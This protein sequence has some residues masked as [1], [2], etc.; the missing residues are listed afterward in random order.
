M[1]Q[2]PVHP[3][4]PLKRFDYIQNCGARQTQCD[5][6]GGRI[7]SVPFGCV[8]CNFKLHLRCADAL[9]RGLMHDSHEHRL[10]YANTSGAIRLGERKCQIC[11]ENCERPFYYC[12]ECKLRFHW[13]CLKIPRSVVDKSFHIHPLVSKVFLDDSLEYC[14][15]CEMVVHAGNHAYC[16]ETCDFLSHIEC[17]LN[18]GAAPSPLYLKDLYSCNLD[19]TDQD[20]SKTIHFENKHVVKVVGHTHVLRSIP[21]SELGKRVDCG[22]CRGKIDDKACKCETCKFQTHDFCAELGK[23]RMRQFHSSH[24]L[25]LLPDFLVAEFSTVDCDICLKP[26]TGFNL[27]CRTCRFNIHVKCLSWLPRGLKLMVRNKQGCFIENHPTFGVT[28]SSSYLT[29]CTIC[30]ERLCGKIVS[31]RD[32]GDVYHPWCITDRKKREKLCRHPLHRDHDLRFL[33]VSGSNCIF[34][35][36]KITKY[37]Y[38][39]GECEVSFH[40]KCVEAVGI[41]KKTKSVKSH[42]HCLYNFWEKHST[43][44]CS[45]CARGCG[46]SFY[47]CIECNFSAHV[48]CI[49]FPDNVKNQR[50]Q[51]TVK[52]TMS[53]GIHKNSCSL[54]GSKCKTNMIY[55]CEHCKKK[56]HKKCIMSTVDREFA[57]EEDQLQDIYLM[58]IEKYFKKNNIW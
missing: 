49:G 15:V 13:K 28:V 27:F 42:F 41:S 50:H 5:A 25:T 10:I 36:L 37:G 56:F 33:N 39:C 38:T 45:V 23:S 19:I 21:L 16:C 53:T 1:I 32:C 46:T 12:I 7:L 55:S 4:H 6:C 17:I 43:R 44:V 54:C 2:H 40:L 31:C 14:G 51:H 57:T 48:E 35:K 30:E 29:T 20:D 11:K 24:P 34:C 8:E 18:K 9:L 58:Y 22:I 47:G 52:L 26:I 3:S